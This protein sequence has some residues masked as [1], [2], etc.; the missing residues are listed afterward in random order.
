MK[1]IIAASILAISLTSAHAYSTCANGGGETIGIQQNGNYY[2]VCYQGGQ[3][4][5][6]YVEISYTR[7]LVWQ[8][9]DLGL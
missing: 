7:F 9:L 6:D 2:S 1:K 8:Y 5:T 4:Y 3:A